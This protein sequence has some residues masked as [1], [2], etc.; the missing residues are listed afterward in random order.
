[1]KL[2]PS[3]SVMGTYGAMS[4]EP[5]TVNVPPDFV[6]P[7][8]APRLLGP[9]QALPCGAV[10]WGVGPLAAPTTPPRHAGLGR[11]PRRLTWS[12]TPVACVL[13]GVPLLLANPWVVMRAVGDAANSPAWAVSGSP[14][15]VAAPTSVQCVPSAES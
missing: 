7:P 13:T 6:T 2:S 8:V 3:G 15:R 11:S 12:K 5:A 9:I 4:P 10:H 14:V 1:M